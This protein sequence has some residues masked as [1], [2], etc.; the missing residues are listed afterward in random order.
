M[1]FFV[2]VLAASLVAAVAGVAIRRDAEPVV[3]KEHCRGM[4]NWTE[5]SRF[6]SGT[7]VRYHDH[8]WQCSRWN[9]GENPE[10]SD[11]WKD[12]GPCDPDV[13]T[14]V[15]LN[16]RSLEV[17]DDD[18]PYCHGY[19]EWDPN[20]TYRAGTT[21]LYEGQLWQTTKWTKKNKPGNSNEWHV[22]AVCEVDSKKKFKRSECAGVPDY[23]DRALYRSGHDVEYNS[24]LY[25]AKHWV[26]GV[27]PTD[28]SAWTYLGHC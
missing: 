25:Q 26:K 3:I 28:S 20:A 14:Q 19:L 1:R 9:Q 12:L 23:D 18:H 27:T 11:I 15:V 24:G 13:Q 7:T 5:E 6:R 8:M 16:E 22:I 10:T 21:T 2:S 4:I 17:R